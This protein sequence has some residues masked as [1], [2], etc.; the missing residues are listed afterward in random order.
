VPQTAP[1]QRSRSEAALERVDAPRNATI[2]F[3]DILDEY[4]SALEQTGAKGE[5]ERQRARARELRA[6]LHPGARSPTVRTPYATQCQSGPAR[7]KL[8]GGPR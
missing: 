8:E 4:A 1:R 2:S 3:V 6:G 7:G 5:A